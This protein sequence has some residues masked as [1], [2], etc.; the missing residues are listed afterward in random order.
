VIPDITISGART[1]LDA[2]SAVR[3]VLHFSV[4]FRDR[5]HGPRNAVIYASH[6]G[7]WVIYWTRARAVVARWQAA[8]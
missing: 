5:K 2:E 1:T 3:P 8:E 4:T 7:A 6:G